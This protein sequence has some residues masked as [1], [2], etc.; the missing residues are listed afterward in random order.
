MTLILTVL[1]PEEHMVSIIIATHGAA[2]PALLDSAAM[3]IGDTPNVHTVT[4]QPGQGPEDLIEAYDKAVPDPEEPLLI[5]V[6]L[7][8][9]SPYNAGARHVAERDNADVISGVNIPMLIETLPAARKENATIEKLTTK[10]LKAGGSGVRAFKG[11]RAPTTTL[12]KTQP[13]AETASAE[14]SA[15]ETSIDPN[16]P[17]DP[18]TTMNVAFLRI[19]SRLIHG[20]VAG[21]WVNHIAPET[22]IAASDAAAQDNLRKT[23]LLQVGPASARTNVLDLAKTVRVYFNPEYKDMRTMIVVETPM[24]ALTLI[25][26]G[27]TVDEINVGGVTFKPGMTL[28]SEA[29]SVNDEHVAAYKALDDLG[30]KMTL[31]QVP[32]S[33]QTDM[34]TK[35]KE[36]GLLA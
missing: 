10:A 35:L 8:G 12:Q 11:G 13:A 20:Q 6:D 5:L 32:T 26:A 25:K 2:A 21:S 15:S 3:I 9:G 4:F 7:F 28:I 31:Q 16:Y 17:R 18:E 14:T 1:D 33:S 36:K 29:V 27:I 24:D 30:V 23:L 22:L 34:M 19:D